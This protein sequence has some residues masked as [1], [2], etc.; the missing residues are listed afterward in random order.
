M[1]NLHIRNDEGDFQTIIIGDKNYKRLTI[2][3]RLWHGFKGHN[4]EF[5]SLQV[6]LINNMIQVKSCEKN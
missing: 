6:L 1:L 2:P 5:S 3:P 4:K